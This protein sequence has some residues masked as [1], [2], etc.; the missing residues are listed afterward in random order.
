MQKN[1]CLKFIDLAAYDQLEIWFDFTGWKLG[2][3][4]KLISLTDVDLPIEINEY[5]NG[6][7]ICKDSNNND[8]ILKIG[9]KYDKDISTLSIEYN[10]EKSSLYEVP[11]RTIKYQNIENIFPIE[12]T[13][14]HCL[15]T[16]IYK[17]TITKILSIETRTIYKINIICSNSSIFKKVINESKNLDRHLLTMHS[18]FSTMC[19][20]PI[21]INKLD[22]TSED[23]EKMDV[24]V[25]I[26]DSE[27]NNNVLSKTRLKKNIITEYRFFTSTGVLN[28]Y[29]SGKLIFTSKNIS[30]IIKNIYE[31]E[32]DFEDLIG[33]SK[34]FILKFLS[35]M[36]LKTWLDIND[37]E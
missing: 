11:N 1:V 4:A 15:S 37:I 27:D 2:D 23:L 24:T 6:Q 31:F 35:N 20:M 32:N 9:Y 5:N 29:E 17:K 8:F 13:I 10:D 7:F 34:D 22:L 14:K 26:I 18:K 16:K 21:L 25:E 12:T 33:L 28:I 36:Q 3:F 30:L 19:F